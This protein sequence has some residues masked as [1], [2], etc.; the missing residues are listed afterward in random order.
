LSPSIR[1]GIPLF[2][3][4]IVLTAGLVLAACSSDGSLSPTPVTTAALESTPP[5]PTEAA[6]SPEATEIPV[7]IPGPT[8]G[9]IDRVTTVLDASVQQVVA[10]GT[11]FVGTSLRFVLDGFD[12]F[13]ELTLVYVT[14]DGA[15]LGPFFLRADRSGAA[16]WTR[17]ASGDL[18]GDWRI[19]LATDLDRRR[20][21]EYSLEAF[22]LPASSVQTDGP[23]FQV[24]HTPSV[25]IHFYPEISTASVALIASFAREALDAVLVDLDATLEGVID[26]YLAPDNATMIR[27]VNAGGAESITGYE[28]GVSLFGFERDGI[29]L[30]MS[31]PFDAAPHLV[32]HEIVHQVAARIGA[33]DGPPVWFIEGLAEHEANKV[34]AGDT[35]EIEVRWRM[36][37]RRVARQ[38]IRDGKL[39]DLK[40]IHEIADLATP[41]SEAALN[42]FYSQAFAAIDL[43]SKTYGALALKTLTLRLVEQPAE[44]DAVFQELFALSFD[45]FQ[46][47]LELSII[48]LDQS[49][50]EREALQEYSA[51]MGELVEEA[52]A[53]SIAWNAFAARRNSISP[54]ERLNTLRR[55]LADNRDLEARASSLTTPVAAQEAQGLFFE[56]FASFSDALEEFLRLETISSGVNTQLANSL[57]GKANTLIAVA[58]ETLSLEMRRL[59][60]T[61][62]RGL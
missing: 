50:L 15:Q 52:N 7:F 49:E 29:Y 17:D 33:Q 12:S 4:L 23:T 57:L 44:L 30:D 47:N 40:P 43:V 48:T 14:P 18:T 62:G 54:S 1:P 13:E 60:I 51:R 31:T 3:C 28:A 2:A 5:T 38:A 59:G 6:P 10:S 16:E 58:N 22:T 8:A 34:A 25:R 56:G 36:D 37:R 32:T 39:H 55:L 45:E 46:A 53:A 26:F 41:D 42:V 35:A 19:I 61:F 20:V 9:P 24:Y 27:E 11:G 21:F